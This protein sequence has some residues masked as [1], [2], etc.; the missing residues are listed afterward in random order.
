MRCSEVHA[1]DIDHAFPVS[2]GGKSTEDNL[3][4][5]CRDCNGKKGARVWYGPTL[6]DRVLKNGK[7]IEFIEALYKQQRFG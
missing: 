4:V 6:I 2:L 3:Q 5:L 7:T 1:L